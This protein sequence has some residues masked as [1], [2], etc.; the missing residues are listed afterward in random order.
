MNTGSTESYCRTL[1]NGGGQL[2]HTVHL[3][4]M[5]V[6]GL[7]LFRRP[8]ASTAIATAAVTVFAHFV[9][10]PLQSLNLRKMINNG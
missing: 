6:D 4:M 7:R 3:A 8:V 2:H 1:I 9:S 10:F 5:I